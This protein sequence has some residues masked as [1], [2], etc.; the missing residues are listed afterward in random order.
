MG[1]R[2]AKHNHANF[3]ALHLQSKAKFKCKINIPMMSKKQIYRINVRLN[4]CDDV[5]ACKYG[6]KLATTEKRRHILQSLCF[7]FADLQFCF[8]SILLNGVNLL[9][10]SGF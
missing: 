10:K 6:I 5:N 9:S 8:L 7:G 3:K 4:K 2:P 1:F